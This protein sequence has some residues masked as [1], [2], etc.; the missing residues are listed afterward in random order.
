MA[1][2]DL[3]LQSGT[4]YEE[5]HNVISFIGEDDSGL[6][7]ILANHARMMTCLVYG[8]AKFRYE[9]NELEYLAVPGGVLYFLN[10]QLRICTRHYLR[11]K[12]YQ[13]I[14]IAMDEELHIEEKKL[15]SIKESL[16]RLDKEMLKRLWELKRQGYYET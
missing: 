5:I 11:N 7:G 4:Q 8:L 12:D 2:F 9:N 10:N 13:A 16:N 15:S 1:T 6:F 14:L 3:H